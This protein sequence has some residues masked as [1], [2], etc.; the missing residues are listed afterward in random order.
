MLISK[1][2][3]QLK[4]IKNEHGDVKVKVGDNKV[5]IMSYYRKRTNDAIIKP[6]R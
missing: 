4:E 5:I 6:Y 3:E 1:L 2:I